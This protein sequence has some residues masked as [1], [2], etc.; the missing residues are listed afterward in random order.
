MS[1]EYYCKH[2]D[3]DDLN[4]LTIGFLKREIAARKKEL[5]TE[6]VKGIKLCMDTDQWVLR[7]T[8][9]GR[10]KLLVPSQLV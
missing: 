3:V 9:Y 2:I 10:F 6:K 7:P 5:A 8:E 4:E 1:V